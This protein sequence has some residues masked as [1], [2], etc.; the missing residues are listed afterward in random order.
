MR[1]QVAASFRRPT[2]PARTVTIPP[3]NTSASN[4]DMNTLSLSCS[5]LEIVDVQMDGDVGIARVRRLRGIVEVDYWLD[6]VDQ[7]DLK[8][9]GSKIL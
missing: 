4:A 1:L 6:M 2:S 5:R 8:L 3:K 9:T 7:P